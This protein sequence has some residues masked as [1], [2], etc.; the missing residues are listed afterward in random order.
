MFRG[1]SSYLSVYL[2]FLVFVTSG[3]AQENGIKVERST[4]KILLEGKAYYIHIVKK[5]QTLYS[6]SKVYQVSQKEISRENPTVAFGLRPGQPLKIPVYPGKPEPKAPGETEDYIFHKIESG[7]TLYSLAKEYEITVDEI[8]DHNTGISI[9][10]IAI[11]TIIKIPKRKYQVREEKFEFAEQDYIF[12]RIKRKETLYSLSRKYNVS[13]RELKKANEGLRWGLKDGQYLRIPVAGELP[14]SVQLI[15]EDEEYKEDTADIFCESLVNI[16]NRTLKIALLLPFYLD[17]NSERSYIDSSEVDDQGEKIME[18]IERDETWVFPQS[19][20]FL[21]FMMGVR[22]ALNSL[23]KEGISVELFCFDTEADTAVVREIVEMDNLWDMDLII[24]PVYHHNLSIVGPYAIKYQ[25][26]LVSPLSSKGNLTESNPYLFQ[27]A[28]SIDAEFEQLANYVSQYHGSN[29]V[30]IH[31]GDLREEERIF[32]LKRN[33][34]RYFAYRTFFDEVIFKEII[35]NESFTANDTIN[36]IEHSLSKQVE[37]LIIVPSGLETFTSEILA[38]LHTLSQDYT[39]TVLGYPTWIKFRNVE[40]K[41]YYDLGVQ[42]FTP[43]YIDYNNDRVKDFLR[44]YRKSF[45]T[46]PDQFSY[47]WKGYDIA[48]YFISGLS[49]Y[50]DHFLTCYKNH[51]PLLLETDFEFNR[52]N[53]NGGYVNNH[54]RMLK[55]TSKYEILDINSSK[56][57]AKL[58]KN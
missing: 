30:L 40:L 43:F 31:S 29:I 26:P 18:V 27:I 12:H 34:F 38:S 58:P 15:V 49:R 55:Y 10:D 23:K 36:S 54:F 42:I 53:S 48:Y 50:G 4:D 35:Y 7:Q 33:L 6:I 3:F 52:V 57:E 28:P 25:I 9:D 24:G 37:N 5:G 41:Y 20:F 39:I 1:A 17:E 2:F 22:I 16:S 32:T 11:G 51:Q 13:V 21:D 47:A 46:E 19:T 56:A 45:N 14:D 8:M 44:K